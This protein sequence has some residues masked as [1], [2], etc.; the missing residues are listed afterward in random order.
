ASTLPKEG[1][2]ADDGLFIGWGQVTRDRES[3][4]LEVFNEALQ[5]YGG[6]QQDGT[7]EGFDAW[8]LTPHGG[9]LAG[10][11]MLR[12]PRETLD[13]LQRRPEFRRLVARAEMVIENL[14]VVDTFTNESL[15]QQVNHFQTAASDLGT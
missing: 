4:S 3:R 5:Y 15:K 7:L 13:E 12:A 11:F 8:F 1:E 6:L 9:D 2:M 14:N 10:F